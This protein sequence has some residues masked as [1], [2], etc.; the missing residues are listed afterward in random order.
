MQVSN[1]EGSEGS[2]MMKSRM[3]IDGAWVDGSSWASVD[4]KFSGEAIADVAQA[5][6]EQVGDAVGA[7]ERAQKRHVIP[8]YERFEILT[9]ASDLVR[10]RRDELSST[11]VAESG[12]TVADANTEVDR[13]IQTLRLSGEE[14]TR[15]TGQMVPLDGAPGV[16][17]RL[18]F[19]VRRPV[20]VV[21]AITPF[22]SPLNTVSHKVGPAIAAGNAVVLKPATYTPL[23]AGALVEIL[24]DAGLPGSHIALVHGPGGSVG[25]ALL[26]DS[27]IGFYTFTGSTEVGLQISRT[28]GLRR[29]QL[30]LG[31]LSS[32]I[33]C[34]DADIDRAA[35]LCANAAYRKAGQVCTSVQRIY[36]EEAVRDDFVHRL[37]EEVAKRPYGDPKSPETFTGP[38]ISAKE[39]DRV[40][41]WI[42]SAVGAGAKAV[43]GGVRDGRVI[44]P[45]VL[46]GVD[47]DMQVMCREVFGPVVSLRPFTKL[48]SA[49]DEINDT[50]Y[51]LAAGI[52]TNDIT[53]SLRAA[54]SLRM[55]S[56][57]VNNTS[58]SRVDLMPYG[59]VK[60]S[61]HGQEGPRY[62]AAEMTEERLVTISYA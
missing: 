37:I 22:N 16:H 52:F 56:V 49:I 12:F 6:P 58:S 1:D 60:E 61:G 18:A 20:G 3:F 62:A 11:I 45:T 50:P 9:R 59:G 54:E 14:A 24:L 2:S 5:T 29:T 38:L 19:T 35:K 31:S 44:A 7:L 34:D 13:A 53:R 25:R 10:E 23:T 8:P 42:E 4:D 26:E 33:V 40:D 47:P 17:G 46:D 30:E 27:R 41:A 15:L 51:G 57:H 39:A 48:A 21:C 28:V 32:T 36:V 55:G 43:A